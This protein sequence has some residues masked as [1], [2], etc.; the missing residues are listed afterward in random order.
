[1][2]LGK[3]SS[4]FTVIPKTDLSATGEID[5]RD[6]QTTP[7]SVGLKAPDSVPVNIAW[8]LPNA[9]AAGALSSDGGLNLSWRA[10]GGVSVKSANYPLVSA[11][12]GLLLVY[13]SSSPGTF[14]L[15]AAPPFLQWRVF[16]QNI[17]TGVLTVS[18]NGLN[19]DAVASDLTINQNQGVYLSTDGTNYFTER[20][21]VNS[22]T[23]THTGTLTADQPVFGNGGGDIKVGTKSGNTDEVMSASGSFTSGDLLKVDASGNAVDAGGPPPA[24][25]AKVTHKWLDSYTAS[26]GLFTQSQPDFSDLTGTQPY[27]V[28]CSLPGKPGAS[29]TV[30]LLTFTR[31]VTFAGN[32]AGSA[33]TVGTNP[34]ATATYTVNKNGS[35][36]GTVVVSTG[37]VVTFTTTAG[38]TEFFVSGDRMTI[39]APSSQDSTLADVAITLAGTR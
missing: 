2:S 4:L 39:T 19:I 20:G 7:H 11:D 13:N 33:G 8:K 27:D 21:M 30:L 5:F 1:M 10:L 25:L 37:G 29:A 22:G 35:S 24:T 34:T 36:I 26:T 38:A 12:D 31:A 23:V 32:F 15:P 17:G 9:D 28:V 18:R 16:I 14:T 6:K 3:V